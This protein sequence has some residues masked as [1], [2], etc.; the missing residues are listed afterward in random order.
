MSSLPGNSVNVTSKAQWLKK[1][2]PWMYK[3]GAQAW[4]DKEYPRHLFI[5]TTAACNL[6]CS[7]CPREKRNNAMD[8]GIFTEIVDEASRYGS[9]S[10]SLHL[11]GEPLLYLR[12]R[13]A[14]DYIK[15]RNGQHTVL[16][17]TNGTQLNREVDRVVSS[18]IDTML[19]SWRPEA[20]FTPDTKE[21]LRKWGKFRVRFIQEVTP[22]AAY[23]EWED[24]PNVEGRKLHNY[25]GNV[26][27][28]GIPTVSASVEDV[29]HFTPT[30]TQKRWAC[31]H[32]WLA[33]AV[34][35]NGNILLCC[36]DPHQKEVLGT[37]PQQT[38]AEVWQGDRLA[39]IRQGH[40][41][42]EYK[43]ICGSCD[44]WKSYPDI[45]FDWQKRSASTPSSPS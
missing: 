34:A 33:P 41:K 29:E 24:W 3:L 44:V 32:L 42:G 22:P 18:G 1:L 6:S 11:F 31:Y 12:W 36:A 27:I 5:E 37:F 17:T 13:E 2:P 25:G 40:L 28:T 16:L 14:V 7:Y 23:K 35:W 4:I 21:K 26:N 10:F 19:W 9:R 30:A 38:V 20:T 8:F 43:G 15:A 39:M 45:F